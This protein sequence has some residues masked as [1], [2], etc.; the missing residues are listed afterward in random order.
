M[1][2]LTIVMHEEMKKQTEH[3]RAIRNWVAFA[4]IMLIIIPGVF[5]LVFL[6]WLGAGM[7]SF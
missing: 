1:E 3:L 6:F 5:A 7:T 2:E 4:G